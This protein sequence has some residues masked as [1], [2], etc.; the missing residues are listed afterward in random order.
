MGALA[1]E[2]GACSRNLRFQS[3][4]AAGREAQWADLAAELGYADQA[5]LIREFAGSA[6]TPPGRLAIPAH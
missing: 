6:G 4:V 3:I 1:R 2:A 5:H